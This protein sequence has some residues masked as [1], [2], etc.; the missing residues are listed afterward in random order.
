MEKTFVRV[1]SVKD[2]TIF[3]SL[4]IAGGVL[5]ALPTGAALNITGFFLIFA[6]ILLALL[7][8]TGYKDEE[9][10]VKFQ[11][12]EHFFQQTMHTAIS[13]ALASNPDSLDLS[14]EDKGNAVRLDVYYSKVSG[15]AY[16]Q[17]FEYVP[18]KYEPCSKIYEYEIAKVGKLIK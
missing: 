7:L 1:R 8:K 16:L 2:I 17:I 5:I 11:K 4:I 14:E 15:K 10:G 18:Y 6:G 13:E 9:S 3:V 12:E